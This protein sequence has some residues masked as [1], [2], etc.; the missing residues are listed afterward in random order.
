MEDKCENKYF[1]SLY[2]NEK[3]FIV[4]TE[5]GFRLLMLDTLFPPH[6]LFPDVDNNLLGQAV[7]QALKNSRT[8]EYGSKEY[9]NFFDPVQR[10][11][12]YN[13][14][15]D[16]IRETLG[17]KT[18]SAFFRKMMMCSIEMDSK[19]IVISPNKHIRS[20]AWEGIDG[21]DIIIP[22]DRNYSEIGQ[23]AKQALSYCK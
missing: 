7:F 13:Q 10:V 1:A 18:K 20:D 3:A 22:V 17:Y 15:V 16:H 23:G 6:I 19:E 2:A 12:R 14:W 4:Q 5:S 21:K 11:Q 8:F 9:K